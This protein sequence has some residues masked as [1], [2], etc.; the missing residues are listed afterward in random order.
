M[1]LD[2]DEE[3]MVAL[4]DDE[5]GMVAL[6]DD[7]E[8]MVALGDDEEGMVALVYHDIHNLAEV[9]VMDD[10]DAVVDTHQDLDCKEVLVLDDFHQPYQ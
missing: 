5:E 10:G 3:G 1:A 6:G 7:E 4:D 8:G 9:E 2:D